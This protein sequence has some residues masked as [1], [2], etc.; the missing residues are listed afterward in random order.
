[1]LPLQDKANFG[2]TDE[3]VADVEDEA[4]NIRQERS[5]EDDEQEQEQE[6][7]QE[8][9]KPQGI[10]RGLAGAADFFTA[11]AFDLDKRGDRFGS[12]EQQQKEEERKS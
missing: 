4:E 2:L 11:N 12:G 8:Q 1:M 3:D 5:G 9:G 7:G 6:Q 10:M